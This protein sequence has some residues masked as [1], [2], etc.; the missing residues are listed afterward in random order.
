M[1][2]RIAFRV[3]A[4]ALP[5]LLLAGVEW[6]CR[7]KGY[8]GYPPILLRAGADGSREWFA[9]NRK[10][11]DTF[12]LNSGGL[13]T[14]G[15]RD[16]HFVKPKPPNTVRVILVGESAMQ[17]FPQILPL[18]NGSFLEAMLRD[19]W[20]DGRDVE[21]LNLGATAVA[22]FPVVAILREALDHEPDLVVVMTG[23]NEFYG[24]YGVSSLP[25]FLRSPGGMKALRGYRGLGVSQWLEEKLKPKAPPAGTLMERMAREHEVKENDSLRDAA[26]KS[27]EAH[28]SEMVR[29]AGSRNIPV[30][31]CTVPTNERGLAPVGGLGTALEHFR[32]ARELTGQGRHDEAKVEYIEARDRD[33]M[34]WRA[35]SRAREAIVA[36]A[37]RGAVLCDMESAFRAESPGGAIGWE[38]MDDHVHMSIRGQAL[39][40]RTIAA[41]MTSFTGPLHV[42]AERLARLPD[43]QIYAA[44]LGHSPYSDYYALQHLRALFK[45]PFMRRNN[46]EAF[47][48]FEAVHDSLLA[49]MAPVDRPAIERWHDPSLHGSTERPLEFVVGIYRMQAGDFETAARLFRVA[50]ESVTAISLW[51]LEMT[52]FLLTCERRLHPEPTPEDLQLAREAIQTGVLLTRHGGAQNPRVLRYLGLA[53]HMVG[54]FAPA[55]AALEP[56]VR[57]ESGPEAWEVVAALADSYVRTGQPEAAR[58]LLTLA[59]RQP[60]MAEAAGKMLGEM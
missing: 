51:R 36:A 15:L 11:T 40:A 59:A 22:S 18:T 25:P 44:R 52:W 33:S 29:L 19:A 53:Y 13:Q 35:T 47:L 49:S 41:T 2:R 1:G 55:I 20:N 32:K 37:G 31:V 43:W 30:I 56:A 26:A 10:G 45:I 9:T 12:F 48:H 27:L 60:G 38:L 14:G 28:I 23:S 21:V 3:I 58:E 24:A 57:A 4:L 5:L 17:G 42:D 7:T 54:E 16:L 50:R 8:G 34:P 39:F 6:T 46:E